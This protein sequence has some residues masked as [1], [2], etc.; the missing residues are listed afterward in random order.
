MVVGE[1]FKEYFQL[2]LVL[3]WHRG[4]DKLHLASQ[5][6]ETQWCLIRLI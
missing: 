3:C 5:I 4:W 2:L 6:L 1:S